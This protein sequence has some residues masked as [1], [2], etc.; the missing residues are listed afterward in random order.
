MARRDVISQSLCQVGA[1][2]ARSNGSSS[3]A[4][5]ED[6]DGGG[7]VE[8]EAAVLGGRREDGV[9]VVTKSVPLECYMFICRF[10]NG[11]Q[12]SLLL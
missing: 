4:G 5:S 11:T 7:G 10:F 1:G 3:V 8:G 9:T 6:R 2:C 12:R